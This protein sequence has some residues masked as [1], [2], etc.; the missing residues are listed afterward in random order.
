MNDRIAVDIGQPRMRAHS[1][2]VDERARMS[3]TG[4]NDV[5]SFNDQEVCLATEAGILHIDGNGLHITKLSL[6]EGHI[7]LEG[8]IVAVEYEPLPVER[9]GLFSRVFR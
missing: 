3:V 4:V 8:E 6:D 5:E 9:R 1:I 7:L 2:H